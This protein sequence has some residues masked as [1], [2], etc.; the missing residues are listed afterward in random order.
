MR[1]NRLNSRSN[2]YSRHS[3]FITL[4]ISLLTITWPFL[5][6]KQEMVVSI[7]LFSKILMSKFRILL[8]GP[9]VNVL[10]K[11]NMFSYQFLGSTSKCNSSIYVV[12]EEI[13]Q[14]DGQSPEQIAILGIQGTE[15]EFPCLPQRIYSP[16]SSCQS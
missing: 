3:V 1:W 7:D 8:I 5:A 2:P 10:T 12:G 11:T 13:N 15:E 4:S 14:V 6:T 16:S 9:N